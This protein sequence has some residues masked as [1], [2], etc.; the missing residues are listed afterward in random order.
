MFHLLL[1]KYNCE[2]SLG[3]LASVYIRFIPA[4]LR[5]IPVLAQIISPYPI[6][7]NLGSTA[8]SL[9]VKYASLG[10]KFKIYVGL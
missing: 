9:Y 4:Q 1:L 10:R 2:I 6:Y 5:L 7:P 8:I 3:G